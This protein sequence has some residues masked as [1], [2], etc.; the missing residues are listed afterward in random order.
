MLEADCVLSTPNHTVLQI[1]DFRKPDAPSVPEQPPV[2]SDETDRKSPIIRAA[3]I[4]TASQGAFDGAF[5]ADHT[6][7]LVLAGG[8][9]GDVYIAR[10]DAALRRLTR[11]IRRAKTVRPVEL[12]AVASVA[13]VLVGGD[14]TVNLEAFEHDFLRVFF[15]LVENDCKA[16]CRPASSVWSFSHDA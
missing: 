12:W 9:L 1:A 4:Y 11:H 10:R 7:N 6:D 14:D 3:V 13:R 16:R 2:Y 15:Q 5:L 8:R